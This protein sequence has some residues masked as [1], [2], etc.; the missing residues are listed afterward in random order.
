[1]QE[2]ARKHFK[3]IF[4]SFLFIPHL[5][6]KYVPAVLFHTQQHHTTHPWKLQS[7]TE[8]KQKVTDLISLSKRVEGQKGNKLL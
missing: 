2:K 7:E 8:Y 4:P 3:K 1:M 6:F 5:L